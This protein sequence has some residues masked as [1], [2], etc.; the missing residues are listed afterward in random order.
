MY[1]REAKALADT[2]EKNYT[3]VVINGIGVKGGSKS[4]DIYIKIDD[5][6]EEEQIWNGKKLGPPRKLKFPPHDDILKILKSKIPPLGNDAL[7]TSIK[8]TSENIAS[9]L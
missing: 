5:T 8:I 1:K 3:N 4:F 9:F 7:L 6:M 2:I